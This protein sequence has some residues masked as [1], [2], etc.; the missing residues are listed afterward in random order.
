MPTPQKVPAFREFCKLDMR[1]ANP[2][3]W[4]AKCASDLRHFARQTATHYRSMVT[5]GAFGIVC[6]ADYLRGCTMFAI[7]GSRLTL[8]AFVRRPGRWVLAFLAT[9]SYYVAYRIDCW[10]SAPPSSLTKAPPSM[11]VYSATNV[12]EQ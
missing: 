2:D 12:P 6:G 7:P 3:T 1:G 4:K 8:R 9:C 10:V 11:A 5:L